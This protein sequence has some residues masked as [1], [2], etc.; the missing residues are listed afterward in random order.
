[1]VLASS[2]LLDLGDFGFQN[3]KRSEPYVM[4]FARGKLPKDS[5]LMGCQKLK[6]QVRRVSQGLKSI[7]S[8]RWI[9]L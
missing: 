1:M 8:D 3:K 7:S 2:S 5:D 9:R 6:S 4:Q